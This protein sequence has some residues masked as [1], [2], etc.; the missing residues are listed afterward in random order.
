MDKSLETLSAE[1]LAKCDSET[2]T[3]EEF[4]QILKDHA[5]CL[6]IE[7]GEECELCESLDFSILDELAL[8]PALTPELQQKVMDLALAWQGRIVSV[9]DSFASNV[10][11]TESIKQYLLD[12]DL[13]VSLSDWDDFPQTLRDIYD[14]ISTNPAFTE[15]EVKKFR[16]DANAYWDAE[17]ED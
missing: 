7:G 14:E 17:I 6:E 5:E 11:I 13:T 3:P 1:L 4:E 8:N 15:A 10:N 9:I 16:E 2:T 12:L